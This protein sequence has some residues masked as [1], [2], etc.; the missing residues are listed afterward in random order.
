MALFMTLTT[1]SADEPDLPI[2]IDKAGDFLFDEEDYERARDLHAAAEKAF[3]DVAIYPVGLSYALGKLGL[4]EKALAKAR[5]ADELEPLN[6][7]HLNDL[8]W[9]LYEA[10]CLEEA[11]E[12]LKRSI[13]LAPDDYEFARNNLK[14]VQAALQSKR[15]L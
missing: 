4:H 6:Y 2:I 3:P 14:E 7:L 9:S 11:K 13:D 15:G 8:G 5:R 12:T 10:G 1:L